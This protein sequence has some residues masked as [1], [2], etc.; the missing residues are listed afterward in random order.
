ME[1]G[2]GGGRRVGLLN[3]DDDGE[4]YGGYEVGMVQVKECVV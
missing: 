1:V 2:G 3:F 4:G